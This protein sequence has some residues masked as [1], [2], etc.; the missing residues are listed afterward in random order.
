MRVAVVGTT[1]NVGTS[2]LRSLADEPA[3]DSILG[4]ARRL[5]GLG[6]PKSDWAR[7]DVSSADLA[8]I[9]KAPTR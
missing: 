6:F 3:V 7:A 5:P 8:P 2:V 9:F 1:G 4:L